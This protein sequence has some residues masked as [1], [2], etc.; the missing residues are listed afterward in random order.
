[1][2]FMYLALNNILINRKVKSMDEKIE[3]MRQPRWERDEVV[4]LVS[5]YFRT[6]DSVVERERSIEIVSKILRN[7]AIKKGISINQKYRNIAGITMKFGNIQALDQK[8]IEEGHK[9]LINVSVLEQTIVFEYVLKPEK[10]N[11][12]AY[13]TIMKYI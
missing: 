9:G 1:M 12:E 8:A 7:R 6:K 4:L 3:K 11:Q 10:I 5:E 13:F 2:Q